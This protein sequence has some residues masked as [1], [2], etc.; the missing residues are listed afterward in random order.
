MISAAQS[1][2]SIAPEVF[3]NWQSPY[4]RGE[5]PV[6]GFDAETSQYPAKSASSNRGWTV[7]EIAA[8]LKTVSIRRDV[9]LRKM[10]SNTVP[11]IIAQPQLLT[12]VGDEI[13]I[14]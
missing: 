4:T 10:F 2:L 12:I 6:T 14:Q 3:R 8:Y 7:D 9:L 5:T 1:A 11:R 13:H